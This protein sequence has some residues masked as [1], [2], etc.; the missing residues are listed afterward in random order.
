MPAYYTE[1]KPYHS[2]KL[3][4]PNNFR[5][6]ECK[7]LPSKTPNETT[8]TEAPQGC[9]SDHINFEDFEKPPVKKKWPIL[10]VN[11]QEPKTLQMLV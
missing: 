6:V 8:L 7:D 9:K 2:L 1:A 11:F 5:L 4:T 3:C 10:G